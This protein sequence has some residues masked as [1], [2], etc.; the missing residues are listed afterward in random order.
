MFSRTAQNLV[1]LIAGVAVG[2]EGLTEQPTLPINF[3]DRTSTRYG[4]VIQ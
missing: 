4:L 2:I 1:Q 3:I